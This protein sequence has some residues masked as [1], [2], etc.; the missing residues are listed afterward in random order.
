MILSSLCKGYDIYIYI[1]IYVFSTLPETNIALESR[2]SQKDGLIGIPTIHFQV[3]PVSFGDSGRVRIICI[4]YIYIYIC[5]CVHPLLPLF[6]G[7]M[8]TQTLVPNP[9]GPPDRKLL[10]VEAVDLHRGWP[11]NN[12]LCRS[13]S[14]G[15]FPNLGE[16]SHH[17]G[18]N[19]WFKYVKI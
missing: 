10:S 13:P 15:C 5:V 8:F 11:L 3:R 1:R 16:K 7:P 18:L 6:H 4:Y 9:R 12:D 19:H 2:P 14:A 17:E